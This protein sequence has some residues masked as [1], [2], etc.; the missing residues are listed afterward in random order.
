M[1]HKDTSKDRQRKARILLAIRRETR[2]NWAM[3]LRTSRADALRSV[4]RYFAVLDLSK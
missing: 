1:A 2:P 4:A 3:T